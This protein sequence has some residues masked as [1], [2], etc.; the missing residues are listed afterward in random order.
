VQRAGELAPLGNRVRCTGDDDA[1]PV[2]SLDDDTFQ[3]IPGFL[4]P[5]PPADVRIEAVPAVAA[6]PQQRSADFTR[7]TNRLIFTVT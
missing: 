4:S 1:R 3:G 6:L 5:A 7:K 2:E